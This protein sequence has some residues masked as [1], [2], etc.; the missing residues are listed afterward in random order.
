MQIKLNCKQCGKEFQYNRKEKGRKYC[1]IG[2][3]SASK[4][5][6]K[7]NINNVGRKRSEVTIER[8]RK[9]KLAD[10]NPMWVGDK[11]SYSSLHTWVKARLSKPEK[12]QLCNTRPALDLSNKGIYDRNLD[13]W[14]WLC[15]KCHMVKD[16][17]IHNLLHQ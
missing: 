4:K 8:I 2:C 13:N 1:S 9:S 6:Q 16:G 12:C 14:E 3:Y 11:V 15:R 17:R 7:P 10:K 5:G